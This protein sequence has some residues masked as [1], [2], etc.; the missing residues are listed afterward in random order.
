M[1]PLTYPKLSGATRNLLI[2]AMNVLIRSITYGQNF[3]VV[4][5]IIINA[6]L[7]FLAANWYL[8]CTLH[9][10]IPFKIRHQDISKMVVLYRLRFYFFLK[11]QQPI[12]GTVV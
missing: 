10:Y 9:N 1:S 6:N 4:I 8:Y 3:E 7:P 12:I 5:I 11:K 2:P